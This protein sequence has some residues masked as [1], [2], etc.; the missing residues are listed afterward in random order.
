MPLSVTTPATGTVVSLAEAR[1]QVSLAEDD[2]T[3]DTMLTRLIAA[4]TQLV[5]I[6]TLRTLLSTTYLWQTWDFPSAN[7]PLSLPRN[8]VS[9]LESLSYYDTDDVEQTIATSDVYLG[10][11][12]VATLIPKASL[13][14]WPSV[15]ELRPDPVS[16]SFIAGYGAAEDV[17]Q[18]I[19]DAVLLLVA[20]WFV[21]REAVLT[22]AIASDLPLGFEDCL[23]GYYVYNSPPA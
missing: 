12:H 23:A 1:R 18:P 2:T 22:G 17:P 5:E 13:G 10:T 6:K 4:A 19:R 11:G 8:P 16:V 14:S 7:R 15:H 3:H 21:N 20:H 9:S